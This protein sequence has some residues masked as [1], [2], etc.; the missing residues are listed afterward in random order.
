M[1]E[2][3]ARDPYLLLIR[4]IDLTHRRQ[5]ERFSFDARVHSNADEAW[6]QCK[7]DLVETCDVLFQQVRKWWRDSLPEPLLA[8]AVSKLQ[9]TEAA[10]TT[11]LARAPGPVF[12]GMIFQNFNADG[13]PLLDSKGNA[14]FTIGH[15]NREE[16]LDRLRA[17]AFEARNSV[18][19]V[20]CYRDLVRVPYS[21]WEAEQ[22]A[23][24]SKTEGE[25]PH[26]ATGEG[27]GTPPATQNE[28]EPVPQY[29]TL[30]QMAALVNRSKKTLERLMN[31]KDSDIPCPPLARNQILSKTPG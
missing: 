12:N 27:V 30:D 3:G 31:A 17:L 16:K 15:T 4:C 25:M 26:P 18:R 19:L 21:E 2:T 6:A 8:E 10:V 22:V 29:V 13:T 7:P 1:S 20:E 28:S 5:E 14:V 11:L 9:A 24:M 23:K